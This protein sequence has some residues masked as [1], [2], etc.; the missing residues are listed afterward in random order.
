[1]PDRLTTAEEIGV[2]LVDFA[3][4]ISKDVVLATVRI[5]RDDAGHHRMT[6]ACMTHGA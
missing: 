5:G 3:I 2:R 4:H 1:M 6:R